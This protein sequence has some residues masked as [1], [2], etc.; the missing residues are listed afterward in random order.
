MCGRWLKQGIELSKDEKKE[1]LSLLE[2][3]FVF[4]EDFCDGTVPF[5]CGALVRW[6]VHVSA[7]GDVQPCCYI[8]MRFGSIRKEDL[9]SI[10]DRMWK[11]S[12]FKIQKE[13]IDTQDCPMNIEG[14]RN[15]IMALAERQGELPVDYDEEIF[16][17]DLKKV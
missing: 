15:K 11:T 13:T 6:F 10:I 17:S 3:N 1:F 16:S 14:I 9:K 2:P 7:Y 5:G 12:F 8:P 4:W